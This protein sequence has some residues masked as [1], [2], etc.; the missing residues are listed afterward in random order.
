MSKTCGE[1]RY[2]KNGKCYFHNTLVCAESV[3]PCWYFKPKPTNGDKI[4]KM[5]NEGIA[6]VMCGLL[7][8]RDDG[9]FE[10]ILNYLNSPAESKER[11]VE[12]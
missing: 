10:A 8:S 9:V 1:C 11:K 7:N 5:S 6:A 4:R 3:H 2:F 12:K